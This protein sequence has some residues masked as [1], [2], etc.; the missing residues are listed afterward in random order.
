MSYLPPEA[1]ISWDSMASVALKAQ[2]GFNLAL[3]KAT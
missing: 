2:P 1:R 3:M